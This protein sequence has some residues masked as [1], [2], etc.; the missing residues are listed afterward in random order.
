MRAVLQ[1]SFGGEWGG[2]A[3]FGWAGGRASA[4]IAASFISISSAALG[5]EK[6]PATWHSCR[7][8]GAEARRYWAASWAKVRSSAEAGGRRV[9]IAEKNGKG[10]AG[11]P[12]SEAA[13]GWGKAEARRLVMRADGGWAP[14][15]GGAGG[16][17]RR[18]AHSFHLCWNCKPDDCNL[19]ICKKPKDQNPIAKNQ[20]QNLDNKEENG[21]KR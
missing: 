19:C 15:R 11:C 8:S 5:A 21:G 7:A 2:T 9:V 4:A 3:A 12:N 17:G 1:L 13:D 16:R 20:M 14:G 18:A 10:E 6:T